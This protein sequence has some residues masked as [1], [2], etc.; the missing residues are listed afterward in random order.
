MPTPAN[1]AARRNANDL[2]IRFR[3]E[4]VPD[5]RDR[6]DVSRFTRVVAEL[7]AEIL[8][9][10]V[11]RALVALVFVSLHPSYELVARV[12]AARSGGEGNQQVELAPRKLH[13][14]A[15]DRDLPRLAVHDQ[16]A[17]V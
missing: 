8:H 3:S 6:H 7:A 14:L 10:G 5:T 15:L 1:A 17:P 13:R 16:R 2:R 12:H 9:V 4:L 11:D